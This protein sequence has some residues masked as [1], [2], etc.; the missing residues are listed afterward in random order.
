MRKNVFACKK[1][2]VA[3]NMGNGD[4][5]LYLFFLSMIYVDGKITCDLLFC[6]MKTVKGKKVR[7]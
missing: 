3:E 7:G 4:F 2:T 6:H 5:L 1:V